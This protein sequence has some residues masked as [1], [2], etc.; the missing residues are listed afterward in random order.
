MPCEGL[1]IVGKCK[2]DLSSLK[3]KVQGEIC[4]FLSISAIRAIGALCGLI[5][6]L[7]K[8]YTLKFS[9][10]GPQQAWLN[11][12]TSSSTDLIN[13]SEH[14]WQDIYAS[15]SWKWN[16]RNTAVWYPCMF[17]TGTLQVGITRISSQYI[18]CAAYFNFGCE[19][20][21]NHFERF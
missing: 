10:S 7:C 15:R 3:F 5:L 2:L 18:W 6:S 8:I 19:I 11:S 4:L 17:L 13:R 12:M 16:C 20:E 14:D 9:K 21:L 1:H